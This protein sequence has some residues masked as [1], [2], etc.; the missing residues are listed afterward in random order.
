MPPK[1]WRDQE[2]KETDWIAQTPDH[3][4]RDAYLTYRTKLRD[5]PSTEDFPDTRPT[6]GS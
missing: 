2:L 4:Q 5:W 1:E 6:L 3:P